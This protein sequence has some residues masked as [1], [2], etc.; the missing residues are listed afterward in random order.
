MPTFGSLC[1]HLALLATAL[2]APLFF[3]AKRSGGVGLQAARYL[4]ITAAAWLT[5]ALSLLA[6]A[7][8]TH[9]FRIEYVTSY[10][11]RHTPAL[12]LLSSIWAGQSGSLLV[13]AC[14]LAWLAVA[15]STRLRREAPDLE[16]AA[17]GF[18]LLLLGF[19]AVVLVGWS[20]PFLVLPGDAPSNGSGLNPLLR[21]WLMIFHPPA[22]LAGYAAYAAPAA[23]IAAALFDGRLDRARLSELRHWSLVAWVLLSLGNVLGM[24]WAYEE[25]GW[26]GYWGWDPVENASLIPWITGTALLHMLLA[27]KRARVGDESRHDAG[28]ERGEPETGRARPKL[29]RTAVHGWSIILTLVTFWLTLFGTYLTRSGVVASVHAFGHTVIADA[30]AALLVTLAAVVLFG[31]I[32]RRRLLALPKW[33]TLVIGGRA[34]VGLAALAL[35]FE[36]SGSLG[37]VVASI[38]LASLTVWHVRK[39]RDTARSWLASYVVVAV[40]AGALE[41]WLWPVCIPLIAVPLMV[42]WRYRTLDLHGLEPL[43][44]RGALLTSTVRLLVAIAVGVLFGTLLPV[45][46]RIAT[47]EQVQVDASWYEGWV[48]P[49][50]LVLIA[51]TSLCLTLRPKPFREL[52]VLRVLVAV[53]ASVL[54]VALLYS[55]GF[56]S[57]WGTGALALG[58]L[59]LWAAS[60]RGVRIALRGTGRSDGSTQWSRLTRKLGAVLAHVGLAVL[61]IGLSGES[62][63]IEQDLELPRGEDVQFGE[64]RLRLENI[65]HRQE[66][67]R[68]VLGAVITATDDGG[69]SRELRPER[70]RYRTHMEQPTSEAAVWSRL[71]GD[72]FLT[73]G[74]IDGEGERVWVK[75]VMTPLLPLIWVGCGLITFGG[76]LALLLAFRLGRRPVI[77]LSSAAA[78]PVLLWWLVSPSTALAAL[79]AFTLVLGLWNLGLALLPP[80]WS[81]TRGPTKPAPSKSRC[82]ACDAELVTTGRFCHKCGTEVARED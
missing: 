61:F 17:M 9:D 64:H 52:K 4:A 24:V 49:A 7:A 19:F 16:P 65:D 71:G 23:I 74:R 76:L 50:G 51:L 58:G 32:A 69:A 44:S 36:I 18:I 35:G 46:S 13:W 28:T 41:V 2:A 34:A 39:K 10:T 73:L 81:T 22:L 55:F 70:H 45:L 79:A 48:V 57:P 53:T 6:V 20:N 40:L 56:D 78:T 54:A 29:A 30:F 8:L 26:G 25:L 43:M 37:L 47:G 63:K 11:D 77:I 15:L 62:G 67:E 80:L 82:P 12:Y 33:A 14:I 72:L 38:V 1:I 42:G 75:A 66:Q 31:L 21:N 27:D 60:S 5:T 59:T 68:E 3:R